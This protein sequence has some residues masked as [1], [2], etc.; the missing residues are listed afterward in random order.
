[1]ISLKRLRGPLFLAALVGAPAGCGPA[2]SEDAGSA[3]RE[4]RPALPVTEAALREALRAGGDYLLRLQR[5]D[6]SFPQSYDPLTGGYGGDSRRNHLLQAAACT[7]LYRLLPIVEDPRLGAAA[8]RCLG[9]LLSSA[10]GPRAEDRGLGFEVIS[11]G[12][13]PD[14][15]DLGATALTLLAL[16]D[17][18]MARGDL[19]ELPRMR[20]QARF[21]LFLQTEE[22]RPTYHYL[23]EGG[24]APAAESSYAPAQAALA[25][26]RLSRLDRENEELW[27][28]GAE[29]FAGWLMAV[30]DLGKTYERLPHD[31]WLLQA[32]AELY[33][34]SGGGRTYFLHGRRIA[35]GILRAGEAGGEDP[36]SGPPFLTS[37]RA[38]E[39]ARRADALASM[40]RMA[41]E[42]GEDSKAYRRGLEGIVSSLLDLQLKRP[43]ESRG[44]ARRALGGVR[45]GSRDGDV[46]TRTLLHTLDA[47]TKFLH[48]GTAGRGLP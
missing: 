40:V 17:G 43:E 45:D 10:R 11:D 18:A 19:Q 9:Y 29:R 15:G 6:G 14:R 22:G 2:G 35:A 42:A 7:T 12:A 5:E 21:L 1:M 27:R 44:P 23:Y 16:A 37:T 4:P 36:P 28:Q 41:E 47:W 30:R 46:T 13:D 31:P 3:V 48:L 25:L 24:Q 39:A 32:L 33:E 38:F 26:V 8:D 34:V 20:R